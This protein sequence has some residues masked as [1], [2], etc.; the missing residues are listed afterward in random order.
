MDEI[1]DELEEQEIYE[2]LKYRMYENEYPQKNEYVYVSSIKYKLK[3]LKLVQ[4][5]KVDG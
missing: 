4:D 5:K 2:S 1:S 3:K